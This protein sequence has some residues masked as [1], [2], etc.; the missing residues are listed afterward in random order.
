[1]NSVI[2]YTLRRIWR[3]QAKMTCSFNRCLLYVVPV[4]VLL[5]RFGWGQIN[6][7]F[8]D[9]SD[10]RVEK[11]VL[12]LSHVWS[13][14]SYSCAPRFRLVRYSVIWFSFKAG[15]SPSFVSNALEHV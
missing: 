1:M 12:E 14:S 7:N 9:K 4:S 3:L 11:F 13:F 6:I 2:L 10:K 5:Y 8:Q 15:N